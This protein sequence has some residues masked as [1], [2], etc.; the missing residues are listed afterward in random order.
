MSFNWLVIIFHE[1]L[2]HSYIIILGLLLYSKLATVAVL[3][4]TCLIM[5]LLL[6]AYA[7]YVVASEIFNLFIK[8][9]RLVLTSYPTIV[10]KIKN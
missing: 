4:S 8:I 6:D 5:M 9:H 7:A 10:E 3:N 2:D 1:F